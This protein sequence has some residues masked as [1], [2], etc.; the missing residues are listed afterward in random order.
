MIIDYVSKVLLVRHL[1]VKINVR[2]LS[3]IVRR[4]L[5]FKSIQTKLFAAHV[6]PFK[7]RKKM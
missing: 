6:P 1:I 4:T 2:P 3:S 5:E 7:L